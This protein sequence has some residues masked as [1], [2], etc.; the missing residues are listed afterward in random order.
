MV[1]GLQAHA[2]SSIIVELRLRGTLCSPFLFATAPTH[3]LSPSCH[4]QAHQSTIIF[5]KH[6]PY[7]AGDVR[8]SD[9]HKWKRQTIVPERAYL[10]AF[11]IVSE[12]LQDMCQVTTI[13]L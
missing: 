4:L 9:K 12:W 2:S 5:V 13:V 3:G 10:H 1:Y 8:T 11:A 6:I 7:Q